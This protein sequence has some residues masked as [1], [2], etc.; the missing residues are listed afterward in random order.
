MV[1]PQ[2]KIFSCLCLC[3][4]YSKKNS[5]IT[6]YPFKV[7]DDF[8]CLKSRGLL[9]KSPD[10][11][12]ESGAPPTAPPLSLPFSTERNMDHT[13]LP[14]MRYADFTLKQLGI[15]PMDNGW[16]F[17]IGKW[18]HTSGLRDAHFNGRNPLF[19]T[20]KTTTKPWNLCPSQVWAPDRNHRKG[21]NRDRKQTQKNE[22]L[23]NKHNDGQLPFLMGKSTINGNFQ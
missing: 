8:C 12:E 7:G 2:K 17:V 1:K 20:W 9:Y 19:I 22:P 18:W 6:D 4:I 15:E 23:V 11:S 21:R 5:R 3:S 14:V 13:F 10:I 16:V